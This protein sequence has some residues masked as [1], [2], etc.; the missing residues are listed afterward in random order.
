[1]PFF[2]VMTGQLQV[3]RPSG[4]AEE[5]VAVHGTGQFSGEVNML[6]GLPW[7]CSARGPAR[8]AK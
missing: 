1:M 5:L 6:C 2:V 3:V 7:R 8:Q 4:A